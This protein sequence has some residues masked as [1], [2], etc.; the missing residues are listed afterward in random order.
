MSDMAAPAPLARLLDTPGLDYLARL[1][2]AAPFLISG[3]VKLVDFGGATVEVAG[4]GVQPA[5]PIAG[6]VIATQLVGSALLLTRRWCWIGAGLLAGFTVAA[7][8]L[9]HS[10]WAF[11]GP[12]RGYQAATFFEHV[13]IVGGLLMAALHANRPMARS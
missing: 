3:I 13:A 9:A 10:F 2:L 12:E 8:L 5:G 4:L 11:G 6:V 7:T 1:A